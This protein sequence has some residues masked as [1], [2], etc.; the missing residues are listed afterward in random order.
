MRFRWA[1]G[2][3]MVCAVAATG[4][5]S[6]PPTVRFGAAQPSGTKLSVHAPVGDYLPTAQWPN[7][8]TLIS[9]DE[10]KA[11]LPQASDFSRQE[12]ALDLTSGIGFKSS[13]EHVPS[14]GCYIKFRLPAKSDG[15]NT[16][17]NLMVLG[18]GDPAL[19]KAQL[20]DDLRAATD[21]TTVG[22]AWG[23]DECYSERFTLG[24][25]NPK[26]DCAAGQFDFEVSVYSNADYFE[27]KG[28]H[29]NSGL[30]ELHDKVLPQVV[31]TVTAKMG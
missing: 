10:L 7:G 4:C 12:R 22:T 14:A 23:G 5:S 27:R 21:P 11:I 17:V 20:H 13:T 29:D 8:C 6:T 15:T 30:Q 31:R 9:D 1:I 26:A 19:V 2:M 18:I 3:G 16:S 25:T 24:V 28:F